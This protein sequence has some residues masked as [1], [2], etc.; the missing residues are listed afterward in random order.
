ML[1]ERGRYLLVAAAVLWAASRLFGVPEL[2]MAAVAVLAL[3][4]LAVAYTALS[5]AKLTASRSVHP[6]RLFFDTRGGVE[7]RLRNVGRLPTATLQVED[8]APPVITEGSRFV[9]SPLG[10]GSSVTMR[11]TLVG[12]HRGR[13]TLG[14]LEVKLRDPFGIAARAHRFGLGDTVTVYPPVW[15]LPSGL[16]LGGMSGAGGEG[17]PRPLASGDELANV[18]EYV[19]GDDLRKVHWRSTAHRGKLMVR[20]DEAPQNPRATVVLDTQVGSHHG[21]GPASSFELAVS[22]AASATYHLSERGYNAVLLTG[23]V[24]SP[25]RSLPW[26]LVLDQLAVVQPDPAAD[27]GALWRQISSGVA[28]SGLLVAVVSVPD[29]AML[30]A[31]VRAGRGFSSRLA[32]LVDTTTFRRTGRATTDVAATADALRAAGWRVTVAGR[33]DRLDE[34][35]REL[36]LQTRQ[37]PRTAS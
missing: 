18:R 14:P 28:E 32:V 34:R 17:K 5:S 20:Q 37:R 13:F 2:T 11:Y 6:P 35:W 9:L 8:T 1:T 31:M 4:V 30:R 21:S 25:P 19:R 3:V 12:R 23:P 15:R 10:A 36:V 24:A 29:A 22:A 33:G 27:L 7:V 26:E 16:P